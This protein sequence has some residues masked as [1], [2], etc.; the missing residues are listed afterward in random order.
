MIPIAPKKI[1][2]VA[3]WLQQ[4]K[5]P[6]LKELLDSP[7]M[8]EA[9]EIIMGHAEPNDTILPQLCKDHGA[10][11]PMVISLIHATQAG[12]RRIKRM[13]D[14]LSKPSPED[15]QNAGMMEPFAHIDETYLEPKA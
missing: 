4:G 7:I 8:K 5:A 15:I 6:M 13:F 9:W 3:K 10:N 1:S 12:E 2:P 14:R 11:A